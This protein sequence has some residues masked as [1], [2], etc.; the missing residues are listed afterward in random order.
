MS[1]PQNRSLEAKA[2]PTSTPVVGESGP[3]AVHVLNEA[4]V[5][6]TADLAVVGTG[7]R[8]ITRASYSPDMLV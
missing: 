3:L 1:G 5:A 2:T 6:C 4:F 8:G 7:K